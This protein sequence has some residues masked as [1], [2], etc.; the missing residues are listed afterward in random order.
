MRNFIL[1]FVA[2]LAN[3]IIIKNMPNDYLHRYLNGYIIMSA[4]A[5]IIL[6]LVYTRH[7]LADHIRKAAF[8][9]V[10]LYALAHIPLSLFWAAAFIYPLLIIFND[11][12]ATQGNH[13]QGQ[14]WYRIFLVISSLPILFFQEYFEILFEVR[15]FSLA[16]ILMHYTLKTKSVTLLPVRS[17]WKYLLLQFI[18]YNGPLLLI[19]N[20]PL[21]PIAAKLWYVFA[22]G[23]LIV[24]LKTLD[25]SLRQNNAVSYQIN[26][27]VILSAFGAPFLPA[28]LF[29]NVFALA[30][31]FLG[32]A[33]LIYSTK[34]VS[35]TKI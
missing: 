4:C 14:N 13:N 16:V 35:L 24:Y 21:A 26:L 30:A 22:Q 28:L 3:I 15:T 2:T 25:F 18:F 34:Y 11:Y 10:V 8:S 29:P 33:G 17:T 6:F 20:L 12:I 19:A 31:Y 1:F 32:L 5:S 9:I 7:S 27:L 23:G